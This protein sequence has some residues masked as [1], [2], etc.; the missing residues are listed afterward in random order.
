M[1]RI[2]PLLALIGVV[3]ALLSPQ[4]AAAHP[5]R[6]SFFP[7]WRKGTVPTYRTGGPSR[8]VCQPDSRERILGLPDDAM[9]S[10]NL[11]LLD[12]CGY[13]SIQRAVDAASS[14]DRILL[15][16]GVY[17]E[18]ESRAHAY[19]EER[20]RDMFVGREGAEP[21]SAAFILSSGAGSDDPDDAS[22][23]G[24]HSMPGRD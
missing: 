18:P 20:C 19:P 22:S 14:G 6:P 10:E 23:Y 7:D 1:R 3:A 21:G 16:P 24:R 12:S 11:R 9:R 17:R 2:T 5:E 8:V 4:E 15:L 13:Q